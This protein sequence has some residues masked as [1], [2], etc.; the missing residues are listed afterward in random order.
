MPA[1]LSKRRNE[2]EYARKKQSKEVQ[3][4]VAAETDTGVHKK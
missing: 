1:S 2:R 3:R 4:K